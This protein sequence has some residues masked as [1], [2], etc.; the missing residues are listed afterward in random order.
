M[1]KKQSQK[2]YTLN[3]IISDEYDVYFRIFMNWMIKSTEF[4]QLKSKKR[5][6]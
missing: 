1:A 5:I 6:F 3:D 4:Y 2:N